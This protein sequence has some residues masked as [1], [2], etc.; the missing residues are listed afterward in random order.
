MKKIHIGWINIFNPYYTHEYQTSSKLYDSYKDAKHA[1]VEDDDYI[2]TV[3]I[4]F[5]DV[6]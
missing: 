4:E 6:E 2:D 3:R 1:G 5:Y